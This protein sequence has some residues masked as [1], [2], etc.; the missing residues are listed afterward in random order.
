MTSNDATQPDAGTDFETMT[1][2]LARFEGRR[3]CEAHVSIDQNPYRH[4]G[5]EHLADVWEDSW[6]D[7]VDILRQTEA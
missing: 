6:L 5:Q 1:I 7:T 4:A 3:A 2:I